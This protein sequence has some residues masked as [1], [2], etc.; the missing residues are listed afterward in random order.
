MNTA[1]QLRSLEGDVG[2]ML[3]TGDI[4]KVS[5]IGKGT[6]ERLEIAKT[7]TLAEY[8]ALKQAFPAGLSE[9]LKSRG[10]EPEKSA[11]VV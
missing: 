10:W 3:A 6:I 2:E 4:A 7:G 11:G 8:E 5:G 9:M 1:R